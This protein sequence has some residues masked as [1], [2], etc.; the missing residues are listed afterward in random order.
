MRD[1]LIFVSMGLVLVGGVILG[2]KYLGGEATPMPMTVQAKLRPNIPQV[3]EPPKR[4]AP[5]GMREY[6]NEPYRFSVFIPNDMNVIERDEGQGASTITFEDRE[7][8]LGFE[9]FVVPH[10]DAQVSAERFLQDIPSG[11][12]EGT[13]D[14]AIDGAIGATFFA[15]HEGLGKTAEIWFVREGYLY[16]VTT[17]QPLAGWL[18]GIMANWKFL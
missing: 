6:R 12:R 2:L 3:Y 8:E 7:Q 17:L 4:V 5:E 1:V 15:E 9:I 11:V 10:I 13:K 16:E 14:V 18:E